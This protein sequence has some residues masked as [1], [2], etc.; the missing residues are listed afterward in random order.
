M[1]LHSYTRQV[2]SKGSARHWLNEWMQNGRPPPSASASLRKVLGRGRQRASERVS[3]SEVE[4][5]ERERGAVITT[6]LPPFLQA[7]GT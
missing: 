6:I 1:R 5:R 7:A 2:E 4:I 3:E